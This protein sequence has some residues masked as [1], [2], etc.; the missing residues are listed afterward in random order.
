MCFGTCLNIMCTSGSLHTIKPILNFNL[1]SLENIRRGRSKSSSSSLCKWSK[2]WTIPTVHSVL[3]CSKKNRINLDS[4]LLWATGL[5][6]KGSVGQIQSSGLPVARMFFFMY[7]GNNWELGPFT[8]RILTA[9][10]ASNNP[11]SSNA[12][13]PEW[14]ISLMCAGLSMLHNIL[15]RKKVPKAPY[16]S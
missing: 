10:L 1:V 15:K 14:I 16:S 5:L 3:T 7:S 13:G 2:F 11:I 4:T 12:P 6:T 8:R 9:D